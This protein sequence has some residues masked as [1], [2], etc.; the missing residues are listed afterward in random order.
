MNLKTDQHINIFHTIYSFLCFELHQTIYLLVILIPINKNNNKNQEK[1]R[2]FSIC[3]MN[4]R[5]SL[6]LSIKQLQ[7]LSQKVTIVTNIYVNI[8][9]IRT[10]KL[11]N[12]ISLRAPKKRE[13][14]QLYLGSI[15]KWP[16][17]FEIF[18]RKSF[19]SIY[20]LNSHFS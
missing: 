5:L 20:N 14:W 1:F 2:K 11:E 6:H 19:K 8:D 7:L 9:Y 18:S 4:F 15:G 3:S 10:I 17:V 13:N 16:P 12:K